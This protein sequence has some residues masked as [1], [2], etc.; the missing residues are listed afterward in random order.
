MS[1]V[2]MKIDKIKSAS[3][4]SVAYDHNE[5]IG[6][7]ENTDAGR[8]GLNKTIYSSGKTYLEFYKSKIAESPKYKGSKRK[9]IRKDAVRAVDICVRLP[10]G[11]EKN[12][13]LFDPDKFGELTKKWAFEQFGQSNVAGITL[14][15]DEQAPH[16]H[17]VVVPI[18]EDGRLCARDYIGTP[19]KVSHLHDSL[20][21][22]LAEIG[23]KR[24]RR[25][26][27]AKPDGKVT[28]AKI[29]QFYGALEETQ[30]DSLP[31]PEKGETAE[32]Y[33]IRA[34]AVFNQEKA[35]YLH[36]LQE[37]NAERD[38]ALSELRGYRL[39]AK[40]EWQRELENKEME[41]SRRELVVNKSE[42]ALSQW[43][44]IIFA[45]KNGL[46]SKETADRTLAG[47]AEALKAT[48]RYKEQET[49]REPEKEGGGEE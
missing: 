18:T 21:D 8:R 33:A 22:A 5:R 26:S 17:L 12:N 41:L 23:V 11:I 19:Q 15:M 34:N 7:C 45:I 47:M 1:R 16:I 48:E 28:F 37:A 40:P 35:K 4:M 10:R 25:Y 49:E 31:L 27:T 38:D 36:S 2:S 13:F 39:G 3:V 30:K 6:Y 44:D 24:G 32:Q 20:G 14:H 43:Q 42:E 9:A 29:Q 46:V